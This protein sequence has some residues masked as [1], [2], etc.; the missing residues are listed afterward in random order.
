MQQQVTAAMCFPIV[1]LL[2]ACMGGNEDLSREDALA[3]LKKHAQESPWTGEIKLDAK[4][5][6]RDPDFNFRAKIHDPRGRTAYMMGLASIGENL[7][8]RDR[9]ERGGYVHEVWGYDLKESAK[10]F[11]IQEKGGPSPDGYILRTVGATIGK[12]SPAEIIQMTVPA[13]RMDGVTVSQV[14]FRWSWELNRDI[15][16]AYTWGNPHK[17]VEEEQ[18]EGQATFV[19]Y[20]HGWDLDE[21]DF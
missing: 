15:Y 20:D 5:S 6:S 4:A 16:H 18:E 13:T 11:V 12:R 10:P 19:L 7:S 1:F 21:V 17:R 14:S 3:A 8:L 2:T 9:F